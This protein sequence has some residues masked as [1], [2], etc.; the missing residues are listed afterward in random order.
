MIPLKLT[1]EGIYSYQER[2][3]IDFSTL[4]DSGLFGILGGV[5]SGKSSIL[6]AITY[7][8]Y[9]QT[10]RLGNNDKR[11]YNMMNLKS[12]KMYIEFDF[13]NYENKSFRATREIKRNSK[14][15]DDIRTP[16]VQ[17]YELKNNQWEPLEHSNAEE[18]V[19]LSYQN[20][21]RTIII[22]Q[23]QFK[24]FLELRPTD[25]T[26][27]MKEIFQLHRYDLQDRVASLR[28]TNK[29]NLDQISGR[30]MEF[31]SVKEEEI[32]AKAELLKTL[33]EQ[34]ELAT[35]E[36]QILNEKY[37]QWQ[38]L[39]DS[40][41][42]LQANK[43]EF[44]KMQ[45]Q[46][47]DI[48]NKQKQLQTYERLFSKFDRLIADY[49]RLSNNITSLS[50]EHK[51][52]SKKHNLLAD[53]LKKRGEELDK[54]K[55]LYDNLVDRRKEEAD[56]A[57]ISQI[58]IY[59]N[60]IASLKQRQQ[61][62]TSIVAEA[63]KELK[64][65]VD[66]IKELDDELKTLSNKKYDS[67]LLLELDNWFVKMD[68]HKK[69]MEQSQKALL[70]K[71]K[72][73][74][75]IAKEMSVNKIDAEQFETQ[76]H[77]AIKQL[78]EKEDKAN[79]QRTNFELK[80]KMTDYA[81]SLH[82]GVAC[83]L[84]G[85]T[86]HPHIADTEDVSQHLEKLSDEFQKIAQE[87]D[88]L[89]K[90]HTEAVRLI[91]NMQRLKLETLEAE[92][93][94]TIEVE[95]IKEHKEK[96]IWYDFSAD[97]RADFE[98]KKRQ[99]FDI[100]K[101]ITEK[102][103]SLSKLRDEEIK[104][105]NKLDTYTKA[106]DKLKSD[107]DAF[108]VKAETNQSLLK[109]LSADNFS[110]HT[111]E[112]LETQTTQLKKENDKVEAD[113]NLLNKNIAEL[114]K[115]TVISKTQLDNLD[116]QL[117]GITQELKV[118]NDEINKQLATEGYEDLKRVEEILAIRLDVNKIREEI[119][120]FNTQLGVVK[121]RIFTFEEE[122]KKM[123]YDDALFEKYEAEWKLSKEKLEAQNNKF[124]EL[125][126]ELEN[127]NKRLK[128]KA[129][130]TVEHEKLSKRAENLNLMYNLFRGQGFVQYVS[131]IYLAQ[132]CDHANERFRRMTRN[133]LSLQINES[134]DFEIV[135]Y[136]NE[137]RSRSVKTL[138][139]G[140]SFQVSLSLALALAESV[141]SNAKADKNF[142]FIDEG[143]GTQD[144]E[145]VNI[146]FETLLNLNK[147][148]KIV[149]IISHVEELKERMPVILNISKDAERG[150]L[151]E[152]QK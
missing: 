143:F 13:L 100:E 44:D 81:T 147:E 121:D 83:P 39:K 59:R 136:L 9:G 74:E 17:F 110:N 117:E 4:T 50:E 22:P 42:K 55:P 29:S 5:G 126:V 69:Q 76:Y 34:V 120:H 71:Q 85:S 101:E 32:E 24:E 33:K 134:N 103:K 70:Q 111:V 23:G 36:H 31:E 28:A 94:V 92:K 106:L 91:E 108:R 77:D 20:F 46:L 37:Q 89:H 149:G 140:Q 139:G 127:L 75:E 21:S 58:I 118:L 18:I 41:T 40:Y 123:S 62:G 96:F 107:E 125:R 1:L 15:F 152:M 30:L 6:E 16:I 49:N 80:Q 116:K 112:M 113:Y 88:Q 51:E 19:G 98:E 148:N 144:L 133:Q 73:L 145:S 130:L 102:N 12:D 135:D 43:L 105:R 48:E 67:K 151:I 38:G 54:I 82:D 10:N 56:L 109:I 95:S 84:C 52:S 61:N 142:F 90:Q 124:V 27:M 138:S 45:K 65:I 115:H 11:S 35:K 150:S 25:R 7:A 72:E 131:S 2:Q 64:E 66:K 68:N 78:K 114:D 137:G 47:P 63:D 86:E 128:E 99:S 26:N 97:D 57:L 3:T 53:E 87:R 14:R 129:E 132:L 122:L 93:S 8:L 79:E 146:V 60:E 119:Q 141:Q 104:H